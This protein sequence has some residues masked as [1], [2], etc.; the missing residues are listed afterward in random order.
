MRDVKETEK[1]FDGKLIE[2]LEI[3]NNITEQSW[4]DFNLIKFAFS[5]ITK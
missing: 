2:T 1:Y 3:K 5:K 4:E